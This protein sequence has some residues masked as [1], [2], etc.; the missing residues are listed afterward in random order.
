MKNQGSAQGMGGDGETVLTL[1]FGDTGSVT[2][3]EE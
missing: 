3:I 2:L 1:F